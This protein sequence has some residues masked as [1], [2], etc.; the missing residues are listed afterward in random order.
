[1]ATY[2]EEKLKEAQLKPEQQQTPSTAQATQGTLTQGAETPTVSN[3]Q[4]YLQSIIDG[5]PGEYQSSYAPQ[6]KD[7]YDKIMNRGQFAYD[8]NK[9]PKYAALKQQHMQTGRQAMEDTVG[10]MAGLSG[11]YGNSYAQAAGQ[12]QYQEYLKSLMGYVPQLEEAA[13]DRY[14]REGQE[15]MEMLSMLQ[16]M[17]SEE[18]NQYR[19][20]LS[21]Y[22]SGQEMGM[23][24]KEAAFSRALTMMQMG[25]TPNA[26][27]LAQAGLTEEEASKILA[28]MNGGGSG[29]A[30][31][32]TAGID[33]EV[34]KYLGTGVGRYA[35]GNAV[36]TGINAAIAGGTA[37]DK[38]TFWDKI[39]NTGNVA[40]SNIKNA[41]QNIQAIDDQAMRDAALWAESLREEEEKKK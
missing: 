34:A 22:L 5:K 36:E 37:Y 15:Q 39:M 12:Q 38:E 13:Y 41:A 30:G 7:L 11:G 2:E 27:L 10:Q 23:A 29:G 40:I 6:I 25:V 9:D 8:I 28:R 19:A 26:E 1:M 35:L 16:G 24:Q 18:F 33:P 31:S 17:E 14:S 3:A 32:G 20:M 4:K 21:D